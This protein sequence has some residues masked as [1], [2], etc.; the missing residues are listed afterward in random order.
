MTATLRAFTSASSATT[1]YTCNRPTVV[2]GD[3]MLAFQSADTGTL[4][5]MTTPT[6]GA[7]WSLLTSRTWGSGAGGK[8]WWKFA[9]SAE[10]STY[11]FAQGSG[12]DGVTI[13][14]SISDTSTS[15]PVF[16]DTGSD[17]ASATVATPSVTPTGADDLELRFATAAGSGGAV[18]WTSPA[19]YTQQTQ[20]QSTTFTTGVLATKA[21]SSGSATGTQN[22]TLSA[23]KSRNLGFTVAVAGVSFVP[24][25]PILIVQPA[26][27]RAAFY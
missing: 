15:L 5:N 16:A 1:S 11:G 24:P 18:T 13:I 21:L 20:V 9:D 3:L 25:R 12:A 6:G 26:V 19:T 10:P 8:V 7:T 4:A 23:S 2:A 27:Q 22:F 14:A 17:V